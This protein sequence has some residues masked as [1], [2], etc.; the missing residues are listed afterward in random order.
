MKNVI[1]GYGNVGKLI[2]EELKGRGEDVTIARHS[3]GTVGGYNTVQVD[4]LNK[5]SMVSALNGADRVFVT[6][7]LQYKLKVWQRDWPVIVDNVIAAAKVNKTKIV[8]IDNI[9]LYGP[10][11]LQ[12]PITETHPRNPKSK[13]GTVRLELVSKLEQAIAEGVDVLIVRCADFYGPNVDSSGVTMA[14]DSIK[15]GK[16]A[17]FMGD[18]FTT[19]TYSY[20]PDIAKA[21][22]ELARA[23]DTYNQTWHVPSST[24]ITGNDLMKLVDTT[25]GMQGKWSILNRRSM[26]LMGVF[27][28]ILGEL[29][30][31]M[32]Q[33]EHDYIFDSSKFAARFPDFKTTA[34]ADGIKASV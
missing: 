19:H 14:I 24:P 33:F 10:A 11:P 27:V 22:V 18:P 5:D 7:G 12:I 30:E 34:L 9:Y 23:G 25:L 26:K 16:K 15:N 1:L 8:F 6:T 20:V 21:T 29:S 28:P 3:A 13:K 2:A 31:M 17:Y 32:Y 4:V